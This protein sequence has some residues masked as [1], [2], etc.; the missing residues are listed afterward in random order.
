[1]SHINW[2]TVALLVVSNLFMLYAWYGHLRS[3]ADKPVWMV[4]IVSWL[5]ALAEY[6]VMIPP[7]ASASRPA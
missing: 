4:I 5:I 3:M 7:T 6:C 2:I 1:M